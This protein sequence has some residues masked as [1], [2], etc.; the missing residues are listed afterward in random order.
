MTGIVELA[1]TTAVKKG[2]G[3]LIDDIYELGKSR[4]SHKLKAWRATQAQKT[5]A[6]KLR[7]VRMV[8]T[9]WQIDKE[10]DLA[11]FY[12]P[13]RILVGDTRRVINDLDD[14]PYSG[15]II[16]QGTVG[17]GKSILFRYL[18]SRELARG[19]A[20]P[21]FVELRRIKDNH[22][23]ASHLVGELLSLG[24]EADQELLFF[25]AREGKLILF[26]DAF[27]EVKESHRA[28]LIDEIEHLSRRHEKLRIVIS[29]RPNSGIANSPLFRVFPL[30]ALQRDEYEEVIQRMA[31]PPSVAAKIIDGVKKA[32]QAVRQ[33]L[34]TPL[35][36]ALLVFR[37]NVDQSIPENTVAFYYDLFDLLLRRHDRSKAGYIRPRKS[38]AG[39]A[40]LH[41][42][43]NAT[44]Y[45][46]RK[47]DL[48]AFSFSQLQGFV[49]E[50]IQVVDGDLDGATILQ[51]IIDITCLVLEEGGECKFLHR[52]VQE[53]HAA[54]FI[55][56]R[57]EEMA[58]KFYQSMPR[59]WSQWQG[60]LRFLEQ[61]DRYRLLKYFGIAEM[62]RTLNIPN[63]TATPSEIVANAEL[64][65]KVWGSL[66][67][68][69]ESEDSSVLGWRVGSISWSVERIYNYP[70]EFHN[71]LSILPQKVP[72]FSRAVQS[73]VE[74]PA[75][76]GSKKL[77]A[78]HINSL[79]EDPRLKDT[80]VLLFAPS[81]LRMHR[82]LLAAEAEVSRLDKSSSLFEL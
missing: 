40:K 31:K 68:L 55:K 11:D 62:H 10:V 82:R 56:T 72:E 44:C 63:D 79:L 20:I 58:I 2:L 53:F 50:A 34:D 6:S 38:G 81:L 16:V 67:I 69:V 19:R 18:T 23:L 75:H 47:A 42:V 9:I 60:E 61:I 52:S 13:S 43:F 45:L 77:I 1:S 32:G 54:C 5:L 80:L 71:L 39:D 33:I 15:N 26:L 64:V 35:M 22:T 24:L 41:D 7:G 48:S 8:K 37:F 28:Q 76:R 36:V 51:D 66:E 49:K 12:Y 73:G 25:L 57:P 21:L 29:S 78:V 3:R 30:A 14:F 17:Q 46:T 65:S 70:H 27:D 4:F 74:L 59:R